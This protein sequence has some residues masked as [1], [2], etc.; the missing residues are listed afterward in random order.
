MGEVICTAT[1]GNGGTLKEPTSTSQ[2]LLLS[3]RKAQLNVSCYCLLKVTLKE[4]IESVCEKV[5]PLSN[6]LYTFNVT[7]EEPLLH[8]GHWPFTYQYTDLL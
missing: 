7:L 4:G 1:K 8:S 2:I 3:P 5:P 6:Y